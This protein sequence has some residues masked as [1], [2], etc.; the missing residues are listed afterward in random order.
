MN[1]SI[2][3]IPN[4]SAFLL[5]HYCFNI[6]NKYLLAF[7]YKIVYVAKCCTA[8]QNRT[9]G[10]LQ[11]RTINTED[12]PFTYQGQPNYPLEGQVLAG[13]TAEK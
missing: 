9:A 6:H 7:C 2:Y 4:V 5:M 12:N 1:L 13:S 11:K 10:G 3:T 8:Q